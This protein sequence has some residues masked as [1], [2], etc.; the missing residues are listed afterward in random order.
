M[1]SLDQ[2]YNQ[3]SLASADNGTSL[4]KFAKKRVRVDLN[5]LSKCLGTLTFA[6]SNS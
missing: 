2:F 5:H 1:Q 4:S 6:A 3:K